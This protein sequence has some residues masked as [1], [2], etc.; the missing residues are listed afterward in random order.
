MMVTALGRTGRTLDDEVC[1]EY[2]KVAVM[3][4][5]TEV[6]CTRGSD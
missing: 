3:F 1:I 6:A 2:V 5:R 4:H